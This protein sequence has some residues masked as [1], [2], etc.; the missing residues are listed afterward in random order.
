[1]NRDRSI[2]AQ[3][4]L[5]AVISSLPMEQ[6]EQG[7]KEA[8]RIHDAIAGAPSPG[9][10]NEAPRPTAPDKL[11]GVLKTMKRDSDQKV[12]AVIEDE[13]SEVKYSGSAWREHGQALERCTLG[14]EVECIVKVV[15]KGAKRYVNFE[16]PRPHVQTPQNPSAPVMD[17]IPF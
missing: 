8:M 15:E 12:W 11:I 14:E 16:S 5:K 13:R 10:A 3:S 2:Q 17:D 9:G 7:T 1:M 6:W 4:I